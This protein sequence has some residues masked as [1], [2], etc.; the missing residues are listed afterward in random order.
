MTDL[1][2]QIR[3]KLDDPA[4][5]NL[6]RTAGGQVM[7]RAILAVLELHVATNDGSGDLTVCGICCDPA[8]GWDRIPLP[9]PCPT[10]LA[11]ATALGIETGKDD[12]DRTPDS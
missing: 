12:H 8:E 1:T 9:H 11:V 2:T 6:L 10:V 3:E 4:W 5:R 7:R